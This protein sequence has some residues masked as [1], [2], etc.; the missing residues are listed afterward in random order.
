MVGRL[1][2]TFFEPPRCILSC[3]ET[4]YPTVFVE[5]ETPQDYSV[6]F[7]FFL[8]RLT[9]A[10]ALL[11]LRGRNSIAFPPALGTSRKSMAC[12]SPQSQQAMR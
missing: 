8:P 12:T 6:A 9:A 11:C 4:L 10:V 7:H 2:R 5:L 3:I 1:T